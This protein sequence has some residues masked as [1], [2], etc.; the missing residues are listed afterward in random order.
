MSSTMFISLQMFFPI[1]G[2]KCVNIPLY[3]INIKDAQYFLK[4]FLRTCFFLLHH[5]IKREKEAAHVKAGP[6]WTKAGIY[7]GS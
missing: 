3:Y 5:S 6:K 4:N 1:D 2:R 7:A